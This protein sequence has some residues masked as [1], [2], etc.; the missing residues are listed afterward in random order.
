M[1]Q[2]QIIASGSGRP[3]ACF[4]WIGKCQRA[5]TIEE[6]EDS[7]EFATWDAKLAVGATEIC[8]GEFLRRL[9]VHEEKAS[10]MVPERMVKGRQI[11]WLILQ[12]FWKGDTDSAIQEF[13]DLT[14]VELKGDNLVA[15]LNDW[16]YVLAG[17]DE[18]P[19]ERYLE[20]LF[21]KQ[22]CKSKQLEQPMA[23]YKQGIVHN[24]APR[25]YERLMLMVTVHIEGKRAAK[26]RDAVENP[27]SNFPQAGGKTGPKN[28]ACRS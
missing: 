11:F 26:V 12:R 13:A 22:L 24:G 18:I 27:S 9:Q 10:L 5:T 17:I 16:E 20:N 6:S 4:I 8:K 2:T 15:F 7:E 23:L 19:S 3:D 21:Y 14:R 1:S 25:S 28:G